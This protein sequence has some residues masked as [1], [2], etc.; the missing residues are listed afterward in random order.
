M[1]DKC[2]RTQCVLD[3]DKRTFATSFDCTNLQKLK[4]R[5]VL[6][7][8]DEKL[9]TLDLKLDEIYKKAIEAYKDDVEKTAELKKSQREWLDDADKVMDEQLKEF[10]IKANER[11]PKSVETQK[12]RQ[13][14]SARAYRIAEMISN[15]GAIDWNDKP[16]AIA[17]YSACIDSTKELGGTAAQW[18]GVDAALYLSYIYLGDGKYRNAEKANE[19]LKDALRKIADDCSGWHG[20]YDNFCY[21][22]E[23]EI[24]KKLAVNFKTRDDLLPILQEVLPCFYVDMII[25]NPKVLDF[26]GPVHGSSRDSRIPGVC[27]IKPSGPYKILD[28]YQQMDK[29]DNFK[30]ILKLSGDNHETGTFRFAIYRANYQRTVRLSLFPETVLRDYSLENP[31]IEVYRFS[32]NSKKKVYAKDLEKEIRKYDDLGKKYNEMISDTEKYYRDVLNLDG[33]TAKKY[34]RAAIQLMLL[35]T[36]Y[37]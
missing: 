18:D 19:L 8:T 11:Q 26:M 10:E 25:E 2:Q 12:L 15:C 27:D 31:S 5:E 34:A 6:V 1:M 37:Y 9:A 28:V 7:C 23:E 36:V 22:G 4:P 20:H 17:A 32:D 35:F 21:G 16:A 30:H 33:K 13:R 24:K 3:G 14:Y 29:M